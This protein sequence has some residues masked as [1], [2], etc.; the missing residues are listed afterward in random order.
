MDICTG[1]NSSELMA[2]RDYGEE[3]LY[4]FIAYKIFFLFR[5]CN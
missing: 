3:Y 5:G 4:F 1:S 2:V